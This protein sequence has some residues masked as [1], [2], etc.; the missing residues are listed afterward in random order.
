MKSIFASLMWKEI[1][2]QKWPCLAAAGV[3][4]G[5]P[6]ISAPFNISLAHDRILTV[7]TFYPIIAGA[8]FG[9]RAAAGEHANRTAE[10]LASLPASPRA[11][12]LFRLLVTVIAA[13]IPL[14]GT[15]LFDMVLAGAWEDL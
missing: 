11:M 5:S 14:L 1:Q 8:F 2:D 15:A 9:A 3:A 13:L 6:L 7:F 12:G 10:F 4:L